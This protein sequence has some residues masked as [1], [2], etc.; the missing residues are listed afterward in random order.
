[1]Q[2]LTRAGLIA[3]GKHLAPGAPAAERYRVAMERLALMEPES[4]ALLSAV[5]A[6]SEPERR[7]YVNFGVFTDAERQLAPGLAQREKVDERMA[8]LD[9]T[10]AEAED[11]L[12]M[13]AELDAG[14]RKAKPPTRYDRPLGRA[15]QRSAPSGSEDYRRITNPAALRALRSGQMPC[16][17]G[18]QDDE[19][20]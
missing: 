10:R 17:C 20:N 16:M 18:C 6:M 12:K 8:A 7:Q 4:R 14:R 11:S 13:D 2:P 3:Y 19:D 5:M 9:C 1:M 15:E